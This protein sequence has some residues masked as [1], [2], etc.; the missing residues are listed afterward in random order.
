[1]C[2]LRRHLACIFLGPSV[3][4]TRCFSSQN[5]TYIWTVFA[6]LIQLNVRVEAVLIIVVISFL[7]VAVVIASV[8]VFFFGYVVIDFF[9][10]FLAVSVPVVYHVVFHFFIVLAPSL[11]VA[12]VLLSVV[13]LSIAFSLFS[14][15]SFCFYCCCF[16]CSFVLT[17]IT[18]VVAA[19][20]VLSD[21][22]LRIFRCQN[23]ACNG[24]SHFQNC[25][26]CG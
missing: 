21:Y 1:M 11:G 13:S 16:C 6:V 22:F 20:V 12:D 18:V 24:S 4:S 25:H 15:R 26:L 7:S 14:C 8:L 9:V 23:P 3:V 10:S 2:K 5:W 19:V 17:F